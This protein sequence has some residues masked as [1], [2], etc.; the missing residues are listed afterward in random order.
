MDDVPV[1]VNSQAHSGRNARQGKPKRNKMKFIAIVVGVLIAV[2]I[3][4]LGG[5]FLYRTSTGSTIDSSK[6]QAVFLADNYGTTYF[7]K[8]HTL[9]GDYM[10][11]TDVWYIQSKDTSSTDPQATDNKSK[12]AAELI[13]LGKEIHGPTDEMIISK[14]KILFFENLTGNGK[15]SKLIADYQNQKK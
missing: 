14:D 11:L 7:G 15:V 12:P 8:L 10:R 13:K 1:N 2:A 4:V 3:L 9:N 5:L 6:Y